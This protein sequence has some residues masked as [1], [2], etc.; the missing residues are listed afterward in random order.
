MNL[1]CIISGHDYKLEG[2]TSYGKLYRCKRC[3]KV[4]ARVHGM[5]WG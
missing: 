4:I 3:K 5:T 2:K 1:K